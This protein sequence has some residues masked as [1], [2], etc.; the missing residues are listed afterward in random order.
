MQIIHTAMPC[1]SLKSL[2]TEQGIT[3]IA[4]VHSSRK[5]IP[6]YN[7]QKNVRQ[8]IPMLLYHIRE[9]GTVF[10]PHVYKTSKTIILKNENYRCTFFSG[11]S[12]YVF[13][14]QHRLKK[15]THTGYF[16]VI[17][18]QSS[19]LFKSLNFS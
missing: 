18:K 17:I 10:Q 13:V 5:N 12:N 4:K 3:E 7:N 6:I 15:T 8:L 11:N 9:V 2:Q 16:P 14:S 19:N 1:T